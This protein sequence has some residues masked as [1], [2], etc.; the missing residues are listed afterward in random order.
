M[1]DYSDWALSSPMEAGQ[2]PEVAAV[3]RSAKAAGSS[4]GLGVSLLWYFA[5]LV[6]HVLQLWL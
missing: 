6:G 3:E 1:P 5:G 2:S 4:S